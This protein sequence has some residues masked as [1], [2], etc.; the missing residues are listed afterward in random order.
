[1][2]CGSILAAVLRGR[3]DRVQVVVSH[4]LVYSVLTV[5]VLVAYVGLVA[6]SARFGVPDELAGLLTA[7]VALALLP[8]SRMLQGWLRRAMYGDRG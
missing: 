2:L 8:A 7:G 5:A 1:M 6:G 3:F 4:A